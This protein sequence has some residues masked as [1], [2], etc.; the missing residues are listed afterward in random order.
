[1]VGGMQEPAMVEGRQ[2][3]EGACRPFER[4][5]SKAGLL[6]ESMKQLIGSIALC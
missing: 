4:S 3:I 1:M 6:M 2:R 5:A